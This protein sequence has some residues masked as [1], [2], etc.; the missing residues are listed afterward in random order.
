MLRRLA[1]F[2][3][4]RPRTAEKA[5]LALVIALIMV[6]LGVLVAT[7]DV[8]GP[9]GPYPSETTPLSWTDSSVVWTGVDTLIFTYEGAAV[10][11]GDPHD[12]ADLYEEYGGWGRNYSSILFYFGYGDGLGSSTSW[13]GVVAND[14][15]QNALSL[16]TEAT[17]VIPLWGTY[18]D[19][20]E[21]FYSLAFTELQGNGA[22]DRGDFL[23]L[24]TSPITDAS[25][26]GDMIFTL[27]LVYL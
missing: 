6:L 13:G 17:I 22:F 7:V 18:V 25:A 4:N 24:E 27:A 11:D 15:E 26:Y 21:I 19:G 10:L 12:P 1:A 3:E 20:Q 8:G 5:I 14:S 16:G 23:T 2:A 9:S